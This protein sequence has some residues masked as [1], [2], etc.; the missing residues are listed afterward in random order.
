MDGTE[1]LA[2]A[3]DGQTEAIDRLA[4]AI[5][6]AIAA[7]AGKG[8]LDQTTG[9]RAGQPESAKP[10][11]TP[12]AIEIED[13]IRSNSIETSE[14][15][16]SSSDRSI[17][18]D[19]ID[20][21]AALQ[22]TQRLIKLLGVRAAPTDT[23]RRQF[24]L[25]VAVVAQVRLPEDWV[26]P[27]A[28]R[29]AKAIKLGRVRQ[30]FAYFYGALRAQLRKIPEFDGLPS[31]E[32]DRGNRAAAARLREIMDSVIPARAIPATVATEL[33]AGRAAASRQAMDSLPPEL[34]AALE[35]VAQ[36]LPVDEQEA[37]AAVR[38][39]RRARRAG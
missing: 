24:L 38:R 21:N 39:L 33:M 6:S 1:K 35:R 9:A 20:W 10:F 34:Q 32:E 37:E 29:V 16:L 31:E 8:L 19:R 7:V 36:K 4:G 26:L 12:V 25:R 28:R 11:G 30:P 23:E 13:L 15:S 2:E 22:L 18:P 5:E 3:I 17:D 27:V 14:K